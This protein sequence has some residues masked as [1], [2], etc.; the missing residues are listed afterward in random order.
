[1]SERLFVRAAPP[2][3]ALAPRLT[4]ASE[5]FSTMTP[6]ITISGSAPPRIEPVPRRRM[7]TP[8]PGWPLFWLITAPRTLPWS[9]L[10]MDCAAGASFTSSPPT[11]ATVLPSC[12][13]SAA[14]PVPVTTTS[15]SCTA[16]AES[17]IVPAFTARSAPS[18]SGRVRRANPRRLTCSV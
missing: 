3:P 14:A 17:S 15:L 18:A 8:P 1:M 10:S 7:L 16:A 11:V 12:R 9:A 5:L 6:S 2:R 4:S 13:R